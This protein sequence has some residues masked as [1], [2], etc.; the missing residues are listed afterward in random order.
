MM[1][2]EPAPFSTALALSDMGTLRLIS[3]LNG[4]VEMSWN[5]AGIFVHSRRSVFGKS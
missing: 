4:V 2:I 1:D 5:N 3:F